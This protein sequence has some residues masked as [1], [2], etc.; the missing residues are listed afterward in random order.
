MLATGYESELKPRV[1]FLRHI[2]WGENDS[3]VLADIHNDPHGGGGHLTTL[4]ITNPSPHSEGPHLLRGVLSLSP[5]WLNQKNCE[6][7]WITGWETIITRSLSHLCCLTFLSFVFTFLTTQR[8]EGK[9]QGSPRYSSLSG[10]FPHKVES[11]IPV[12]G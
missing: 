9:L 11:Q 7:L 3:C 2:I 12:S 6:I 5:N 8:L 10:E 4:L 1:S